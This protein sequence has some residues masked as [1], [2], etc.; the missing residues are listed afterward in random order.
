MSDNLSL[1]LDMCEHSIKCKV[2]NEANIK[3]WSIICE[4][5]RNQVWDNSIEEMWDFFRNQ[6]KNAIED[7]LRN[8]I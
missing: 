3:L 7:S 1:Q 6:C 4:K 8:Q 5:A 2:I